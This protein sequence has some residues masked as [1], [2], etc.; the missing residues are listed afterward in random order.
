MLAAAFLA[1][2]VGAGQAQEAGS[3]IGALLAAADAAKGQVSLK[4]C[5]ACHD[6]T[7]GGPNKIGPN[8]WGVVGRPVASVANFQYSDGMKT[9]ADG[10]KTW[11][12]DELNAYLTNPKAHVPG[13]KMAFAGL[14]KDDERANVIAYLNTLSDSPQ[15]LPAAQ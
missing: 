9:F 7:K 4:K 6:L 3:N 12:F 8:L 11:T 5:Q 13:N 2:L 1:S 14:K 10:G 15:P